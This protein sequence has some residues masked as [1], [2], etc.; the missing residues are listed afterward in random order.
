MKK[1]ILITVLGLII[2][3]GATVDYLIPRQFP[4]GTSTYWADSTNYIV[5]NKGGYYRDSLKTNGQVIAKGGVQFDTSGAG[6]MF[7]QG[8]DMN[9]QNTK[10]S[11]A[12][13]NSVATGGSF[14]WYGQVGHAG[15]Q[16]GALDNTNGLII[17]NDIK[18][19]GAT[20]QIHLVT[21]TVSDYDANDV[22]VLNKQS[23]IITTKSLSIVALATYSLTLTN[24]LIAKYS[25]I[26]CT[27]AGGTNTVKPVAITSIAAGSGTATIVIENVNAISILNGNVVLNI[28]IFNN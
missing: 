18:T 13:Y 4:F 19:S 6:Q 23:C 8:N 25:N 16:F 22:V 5:Y 24:S 2:L 11:G 20:T 26:Q 28:L 21:D 17:Y 12:I 14:Y 9:I 15:T 10:T 7:F 27:V 3:A 1:S